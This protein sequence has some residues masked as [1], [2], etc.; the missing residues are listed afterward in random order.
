MTD[1]FDRASEREQCDRDLA[2]EHERGHY[3][4]NWEVD[5]ATECAGCGAQIPEAR[6]EAI[7]GVQLCVECQAEAERAARQYRK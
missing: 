3:A 7:P 2:I 6:R 1:E 5:S 4:R